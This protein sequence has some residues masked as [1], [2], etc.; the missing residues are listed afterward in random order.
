MQFYRVLTTNGGR[1]DKVIEY[2]AVV[3]LEDGRPFA[4]WTQRDDARAWGGDFAFHIEGERW[5]I[6]YLDH[7]EFEGEVVK[8]ADIPANAFAAM[9]FAMT[10]E[11]DTSGDSGLDF[12]H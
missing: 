5:I 3:Q 10:P 8:P 12:H 4:Y 9:M 6:G 1:S 11:F 2:R 7:E